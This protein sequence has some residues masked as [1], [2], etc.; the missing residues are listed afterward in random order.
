MF[1]IQGLVF[2]H[3]AVRDWEARLAPRLAECLRQ[4]RAEGIKG[5]YRSMR[6]FKAFNAADRFCRAFDET[7]SARPAPSIRKFHWRTAG[8]STFSAWLRCGT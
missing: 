8:L 5:R 3:E 4:R 6:G 7:S 1:L 2:T